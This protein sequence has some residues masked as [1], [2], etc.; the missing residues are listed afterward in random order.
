MGR[1]NRCNPG[2]ENLAE[3]MPRWGVRGAVSR[4]LTAARRRE[5]VLN[6][7]FQITGESTH[8]QAHFR[9]PFGEDSRAAEYLG[10]HP[11]FVAVPVAGRAD[12][13]LAG[14]GSCHA[15][16]CRRP[17]RGGFNQP[18]NASHRDDSFARSRRGCP[19]PSPAALRAIRCDPG[20]CV[21]GQC[22]RLSKPH[23]MGR[24][25]DSETL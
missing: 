12:E 23:E 4:M 13:A 7:A 22:G 2:P 24:F 18:R 11:L 6:S 5:K 14:T 9:V 1:A 16:P 21:I 10:E 25:C 3:I 19:E 20:L 17:N 8:G 15:L